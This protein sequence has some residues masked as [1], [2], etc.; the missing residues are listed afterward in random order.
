MKFWKTKS[1]Y[2]VIQILTG[3]SNVF[4]LTNGE[5]SILI[6]TGPKFMWRSLKKRLKDLNLTYID[7]LILTHSHFDHANN[8]AGLKEKYKAKVIIHRNEAAYLMSNEVVL[9]PGSNRVTRILINAFGKKLRSKLACVPCQPDIL[10]DDRFNLNDFGLNAYIMHTP[11]HSC[12]SVSVIVDNEIALVG[13]TM[14]GVFKR[15]VFPPFVQDN[16]QLFESWSKLLETDCS[17]FIPSHGSTNSRWLLQKEYNK[18]T[19]QNNKY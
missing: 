5:K 6:D 13:D 2:R 1:G 18:S 7:Y 3:R 10:I 9:P 19:G 4:L 12:G 17:L 8:A 14:F 11:G 16:K 15:S